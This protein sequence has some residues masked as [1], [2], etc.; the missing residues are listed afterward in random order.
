MTKEELA[1]ITRT[2]NG[3]HVKDLRWLPLD[4]IIVGLVKDDLWGNDNINDGYISGQ[5]KKNGISTNKIK[6]RTDLNLEIC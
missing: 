1:K 2:K 5:W 4:N 6:G 3:S